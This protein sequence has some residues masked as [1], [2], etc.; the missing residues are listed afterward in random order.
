LNEVLTK[1][2]RY[3]KDTP[4]AEKL[5]NTNGMQEQETSVA[6]YQSAAHNHEDLQLKYV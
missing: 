4:T 2:T 5:R 3:Y 1:L 6:A